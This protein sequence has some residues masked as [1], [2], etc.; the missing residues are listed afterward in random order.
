MVKANAAL[1][2][3]CW[4]VRSCLP[5]SGKLKRQ[6]LAEIRER[7]SAYLEQDPDADYKTIAAQFGTPQ[8]IASA[9]VDEMETPE[10]LHS[11]RIRRRIVKIISAAAAAMLM[12][13]AG[14]MM[15]VTIKAANNLDGYCEVAIEEQIIEQSE[16]GDLE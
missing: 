14:G 9:Y 12:L 3:Y 11:L 6:I 10:L 15:L 1:N 4:D 5:C 8:Q 2:R 16:Q 7:V 13:W